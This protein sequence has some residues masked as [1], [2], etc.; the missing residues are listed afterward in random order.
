MYVRRKADI[1][2]VSSVTSVIRV[3]RAVVRFIDQAT[4]LSASAA[5]SKSNS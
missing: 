1:S 2:I 5:G 4:M 3:S